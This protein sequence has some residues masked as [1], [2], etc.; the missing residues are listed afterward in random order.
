MPCTTVSGSLDH[1]ISSK[2]SF[3][4]FVC[5]EV[6]IPDE[7]DS[8]YRGQVTVLLKDSVLQ[9]SSPFRHAAEMRQLLEDH[10][11][12]A[13]M[14]Y[15]DGG[16]DHRLTYH[17]VQLSLVSLLLELNLDRLIVGRT[18][19]WHSWA[20]PVERL[21]SLL[22]L[23]YQNVAHSREFC[24]ADT[25]HKLKS[26]TGMTEIRKLCEKN[27][28]VRQEWSKSIQPIIEVLNDRTKRVSLKGK[29]L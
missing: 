2:G 9:A 27:K 28:T 1:D 18:T 7:L 25:E 11:N 6:D 19:P 10:V 29:Q 26:C 20:N 4:P 14:I 21:M 23:A 16:P 17:S 24:S 8:F 15:S 5:L 13:L 3:T 12:P 22:N